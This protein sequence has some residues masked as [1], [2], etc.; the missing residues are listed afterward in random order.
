MTI[1]A[2]QR[3]KVIEHF[4][5]AARRENLETNLRWDNHT[6]DLLDRLY[7]EYRGDRVLIIDL[8]NQTNVFSFD[9]YFKGM[10]WDDH[11]ADVLSIS[12]TKPDT[13]LDKLWSLYRM[14]IHDGVSRAD[15]E[16]AFPIDQPGTAF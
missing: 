4:S 15:I 13:M 11:Q 3:R 16:A 1:L 10:A 8:S 6:L 2:K 12:V 14:W 9:Y 7:E 5:A